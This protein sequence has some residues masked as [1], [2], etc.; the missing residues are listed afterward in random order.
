LLICC[1][2]SEAFFAHPIKQQNHPSTSFPF[3]G[4]LSKAVMYILIVSHTIKEN[5]I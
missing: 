2:L 1:P 3:P 4:L 5:T